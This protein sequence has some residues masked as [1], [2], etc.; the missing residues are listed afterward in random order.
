M[1]R[2]KASSVISDV[3][4]SAENLK[5]SI[6]ALP[7]EMRDKIMDL[8]LTVITQPVKRR[9]RPPRKVGRSRKMVRP[10]KRRGPLKPKAEAPA[11]A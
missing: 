9:G 8:A 11:Q 1:P 6:G 10:R 4:A 3:L 2:R 7:A 5:N